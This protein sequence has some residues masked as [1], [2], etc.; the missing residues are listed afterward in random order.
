MRRSAA[1]ERRASIPRRISVNRVAAG[2]F[3]PPVPAL[4]EAP[5]PIRFMR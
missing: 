5:Y 4:P 3:S 2:A 1:G